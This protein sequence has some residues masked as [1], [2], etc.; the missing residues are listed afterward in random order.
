MS[1]NLIQIKKI[2]LLVFFCISATGTLFAQKAKLLLV[3]KQNTKPVPYATIAW[4]ELHNASNKGYAVSNEK[5]EAEL[6]VR[7]GKTIILTVSSIGCKSLCDTLKIE[8]SQSIFIEEDVLNLSQI[9]VTGT[10]TQHTLKNA[11][12]LTQ[13]ITRQEIER[14]DA[15]GITDVLEAE[16]PGMEMNRNGYGAN[17]TMQGLDAQYT[18]ILIDGERMAGET[19]GNVDYSRINA[20]NI[21]RIEIVRGASSTLYGSNAMGG[22]VNVITKKARKKFDISAGWR[23]A[24]NNQKNYHLGSYH[25]NYEEDFYKNQDKKN[26]NGN[27]SLGYRNKNF[28]TNTFFNLKSFDGYVLSDK[29]GLKHRYKD[30]DTTVVNDLG[31]TGISG[32]SDYSI[33]H[34]TGY[35]DGKK[36]AA[37]LR[38]RFYKHEVFPVSAGNWLH[39][40]YK[41]YTLGGHASH[42]F[43]KKSKLKLSHNT[44]IYDK[45]DVYERKNN[46]EKLNYKN[47]F[48]NTRLS[49]TTR[50]AGKHN[51]FIGAENLSEM[52][53]TDMFVYDASEM[54]NKSTYDAVIVLQDEYHISEKLDAVLGVR[55]GYH[56]AFKSHFSP[57]ATLKYKPADF[58]NLRA[59][60]ARG[61]RSPTLKE[62]YM[63][64]DHL[65]MFQIIGNSNLQPETNDYFAFSADL[66]DTKRKL[67]LSL[68]S[69]Y[70]KVYDKIDGVWQGD[71]VVTYLNLDDVN[72]FNLEA[73]VKWRAHRHFNFKGG[74]VY[75]HRK[76]KTDAISLSEVSPHA[77]SSQFEFLYSLK[78]LRLSAN[79]AGKFY[80]GKTVTSEN[81][82]KE[83]TLYGK[84][85]A[86]DYPA[87]WLWNFTAN[88]HYG[89]HFWVSCGFKNL[90]DY[91]SPTVTM[92]TS[93]SIGRRF[94]MTI[95]CKL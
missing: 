18:L 26:L 75:T 67:N 77:L 88:I 3:E 56:S 91:T 53:K 5:G 62:L 12:V 25:L 90:F 94:F 76:R 45:Y 72:L 64:W 23:Y 11:P 44:D 70:N 69:S 50:I 19:G 83:S 86:I 37:E 1:K 16:M 9:T 74:Y 13:V 46:E 31:S 61:F 58:L 84:K 51:V 54:V 82:N 85:Y 41:S 30:V 89:R 4:Q 10:R 42:R 63:N 79:L 66:I 32:F 57:S 80:G 52:L 33:S 78:K 48:H 7:L 65:G 73:I 35:D 2:T 40:L 34:K 6:D 14:T 27:L 81:T 15:T 36:W 55:T 38:G 20:S 39:D 24:Q 68:I 87:Y 47:T 29:E 28:Y 49:Y 8:A 92:N 17:M 93:P 59:N 21:E 71:S 60:Y 95:N 43:S 22:V